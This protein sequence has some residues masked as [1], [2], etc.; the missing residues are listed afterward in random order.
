MDRPG[1]LARAVRTCRADL[2]SSLKNRFKFIAPARKTNV[3]RYLVTE[4][5]RGQ[6]N[7]DGDDAK[8]R[9][10]I[11]HRQGL[12]DSVH[13]MGPTIFDFSKYRS[14]CDFV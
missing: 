5:L 2:N 13:I 6:D 11:R 14:A 9:V 3:R 10:K 1:V 12:S 4:L 7:P 8:G